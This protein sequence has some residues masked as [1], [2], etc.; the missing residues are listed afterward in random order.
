MVQVT[1][2]GAGSGSSEWWSDSSYI[3]KIELRGFACGCD[4]GVKDDPK[5]G[6]ID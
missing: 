5:Y 4:R 3:L 2:D 1:D 6:W